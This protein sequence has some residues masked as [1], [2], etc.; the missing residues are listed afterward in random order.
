[1][2]RFYGSDQSCLTPICLCAEFRW[3]SSTDSGAVQ[4]VD[5]MLRNPWI[6]CSG[7]SG[8]HVP[9]LLDDFPRIM[10]LVSFWSTNTNKYKIKRSITPA[11]WDRLRRRESGK[12]GPIWYW[13]INH[14]K[15]ARR[16]MSFYVNLSRLLELGSIGNVLIFY[17]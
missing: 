17:N 13:L 3:M 5:G 7:F 11:A 2:T 6:L 1:M 4:K 9:D 8:R 15:P 12:F 10:Q 14:Q 16:P